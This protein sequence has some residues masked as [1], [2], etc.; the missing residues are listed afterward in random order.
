MKKVI[1]VLLMGLFGAK[2]WAEKEPAH[3]SH[4]HHQHGQLE[5]S[6]LD[7]PPK[8][9]IKLHPDAMSGWNLEVI[10]E[11]FE[12]APEQVN[13][14]HQPGKGHA[15]LYIDGKKIGRLYSHWRHINGVA[16]GKHRIKVTLNSNDH[17][18]YTVKGQTVGHELEFIQK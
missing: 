4:S 17:Q 12:F 14:P 13:Q 18:D 15:H 10:T 6:G 7:K 1:L 2:L 9:V 8:V 11:N 3:H 16:T 5:V